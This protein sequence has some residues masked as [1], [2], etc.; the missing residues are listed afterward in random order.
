MVY[1]S[2]SGYYVLTGKSID[3]DFFPIFAFENQQSKLRALKYFFDFMSAKEL[4]IK[5]ADVAYSVNGGYTRPIHRYI[6]E[7]IFE[8]LRA[9]HI[10]HAES[11][12]E[13]WTF[14]D[15]AEN[16][17]SGGEDEI[18]VEYL[19]EPLKKYPEDLPL[20]MLDAAARLFMKRFGDAFDKVDRLCAKDDKYCYGFVYMAGILS[21]NKEYS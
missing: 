14:R 18:V 19:E 3:I 12:P 1:Y 20:R 13:L 2:H 4:H 17:L 10:L 21:T 7:E 15:T 11:P 6:G 5:Y 9:P 8:I 16:M